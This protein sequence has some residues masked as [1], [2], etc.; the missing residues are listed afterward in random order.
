MSP[1]ENKIP[2]GGID[3]PATG[4]E[5]ELQDAGHN[6]VLTQELAHRKHSSFADQSGMQRGDRNSEREPA[7]GQWQEVAEQILRC[8]IDWIDEV[9]GFLDC[10]GIESHTTR[11]GSKDC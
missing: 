8:S 9:T 1:P 5:Y 10:P 4:E 11:N 2:A 6:F 7:W 3:A